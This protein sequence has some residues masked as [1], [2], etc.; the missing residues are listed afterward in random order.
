MS[1]LD[2]PSGHGQPE[3]RHRA[4]LMQ[5][6]LVDPENLAR[7]GH[8]LANEGVWLDIDALTQCY[9]CKLA[10]SARSVIFCCPEDNSVVVT[11]IFIPI[12]ICPRR[13]KL[14]HHTLGCRRPPSHRGPVRPPCCPGEAPAGHRLVA[15][16]DRERRSR[17]EAVVSVWW[18]SWPTVR[19]LTM[20]PQVTRSTSGQALFI[21]P[22]CCCPKQ[23]VPTS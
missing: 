21:T 7:I 14:V 6:H 11:R 15:R 9:R 5:G 4:W 22:I 13:L 16:L 17:S 23:K 1:G 18:R 3:I 20:F 8:L 2:G 19:W 10:L 12:G